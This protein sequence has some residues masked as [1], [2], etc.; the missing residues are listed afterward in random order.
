MSDLGIKDLALSL[1]RIAWGLLIPYPVGFTGQSLIAK[2][3]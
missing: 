1:V 2:H 3:Q